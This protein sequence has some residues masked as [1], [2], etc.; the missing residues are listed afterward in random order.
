MNPSHI[1]LFKYLTTSAWCITY[2]I[3]VNWLKHFIY[4]LILVNIFNV[5]IKMQNA[6]VVDNY[7]KSII[8]SCIWLIIIFHLILSN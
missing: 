7:H 5:V 4:W 1:M 3:N 2:L 6:A 8:V